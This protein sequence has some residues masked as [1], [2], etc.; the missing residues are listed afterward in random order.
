MMVYDLKLMNPSW[1]ET[2]VHMLVQVLIVQV[3]VGVRM[4]KA[5]LTLL[6]V[7]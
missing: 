2:T 4:T 6:H 7:A 1:S 5:G 3:L